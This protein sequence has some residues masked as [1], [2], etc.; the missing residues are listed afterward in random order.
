MKK[1]VVLILG[2]VLLLCM[3]S[4]AL[5]AKKDSAGPIVTGSNPYDYQRNTLV[6][7]K[8]IIRFNEV[9]QKGRLFTRINMQD[10]NGN[11]V[12]CTCEV[13]DNVLQVWPKKKL[14]YTSEYHVVVPAGAVKDASGNDLEKQYA[15]AFHTEGE[16]TANGSITQEQE[17]A[18]KSTHTIDI[19]TVMEGTLS[20]AEKSCLIAL[21]Q[22]FGIQVN[23]IRVNEI[24]ENADEK[25]EETEEITDEV[26]TEEEVEYTDEA[27]EYSEFDLYLVEV[28]PQKI[29]V[30]KAVRE[31]TALG[32]REAKDLVDGVERGPRIVKEG[33]ASDEADQCSQWLEEQGATTLIVGHG[34]SAD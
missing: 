20:N 16:S 3:V 24:E 4:P 22:S 9:I 33:I 7:S 29:L 18:S 6:E 27:K 17:E 11:V 23:N 21:F 14:K 34:E 5:A 8:L 28:G 30:I 12:G 1:I 19:D 13:K 10:S 26:V 32:L 15:M 31:I 2:L 25:P